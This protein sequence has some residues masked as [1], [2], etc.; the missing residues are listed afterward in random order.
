LG[1]A[2]GESKSMER[3]LLELTAS[4]VVDELAD[5]VLFACLD[6]LEAAGYAFL[7]YS[8]WVV[9]TFAAP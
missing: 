7:P 6:L 8:A 2:S 5:Q 3:T 1:A 4:A 9:E